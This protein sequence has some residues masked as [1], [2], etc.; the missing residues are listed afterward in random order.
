ML[1]SNPNQPWGKSFGGSLGPTASPRRFAK[2]RRAAPLILSDLFPNCT[3][4]STVEAAKVLLIKPQ[5]MRRWASLQ[6]GPL[7]PTKVGVRLLWPLPDLQR[8]LD[9]QAGLP[10]R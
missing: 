2:A 5:T 10:A 9:Q 8:V 6:D 7:Q 3:G 1:L 4:L